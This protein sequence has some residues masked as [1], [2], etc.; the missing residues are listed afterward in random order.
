MV[1]NIVFCLGTRFG[2]KTGVWAQAEQFLSSSFLFVFFEGG[3]R[4]MRKEM[5]IGEKIEAAYLRLIILC[6]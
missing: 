2:S 5:K 1:D 3:G 4:L 6:P